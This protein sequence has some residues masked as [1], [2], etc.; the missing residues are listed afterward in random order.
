MWVSF[1]RRRKA[2]PSISRILLRGMGIRWRSKSRVETASERGQCNLLSGDL[3]VGRSQFFLWQEA[4]VR[5]MQPRIVKGDEL[6][7][8]V[9]VRCV[10]KIGYDAEDDSRLRIVNIVLIFMQFD[11][12]GFV[13]NRR[14]FL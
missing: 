11:V 12:R 6:Q 4:I 8:V 10:S 13:Q 3:S 9:C 14:R 5:F 1:I 2:R 7:R